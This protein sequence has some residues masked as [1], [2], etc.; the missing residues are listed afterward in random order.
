[1]DIIPGRFNAFIQDRGANKHIDARF[2]SLYIRFF[3]L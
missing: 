3:S 1:M 2:V